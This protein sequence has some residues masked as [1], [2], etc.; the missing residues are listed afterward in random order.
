VAGRPAK[1][2]LAHV[3]EG[4][5]RARRDTHR[6]L[7]LG[8]PLKWPL[9]AS[10]QV[11]YAQATSQPERRAV[12][13]EFELLVRAA[14]QEVRR[15]TGT[16]GGADMRAALAAELASLGSHTSA[17]TLP[18]FFPEYLAHPKGPLL[19]Q[20]FQLERW[21]QQ[22][23]R[24]FYRRDKHGRRVYQRGVLGVPRGNGKTPLA[25]ALGL[26]E[27]LART[28][29]PEIY[30]A[31]ASKEQ[32][33][34]A[35]G[36]ARD[37][38][39]QGPLIDWVQVKRTLTCPGSGGLMQ[40][41]SSEGR[42]QHGR[43][44]AVALIDE[45]WAFLTERE[46]QTYTALASALHKRVDAYLLAITTAG[47]KQ[48][49]LLGDIYQA[50]LNGPDV[51]T[52]RNGCLTVAKDIDN[53]QLLWWYGAPEGATI[54]DPKIWRAANP[55]SWL[56]PHDLKHQLA[57]P[58]LGEHEFRRLHLNQWTKQRNAWLPDRC[59]HNLRS[60]LEIPKGGAIYV[61]VDVGITHDTTAVCLAHVHEDG[62]IILRAHVWAAQTDVDA[63]V[64]MGGG[65]VRL[66]A[67]ED[68][69]RQLARDYQLRELAYD[70]HF[71][72]RSAQ[73]LEDEGIT[74]VEFHPASG[75]MADAYQAFY[76][77]AKEG[78]LTHNGDPILTDHIDATGAV[79]TERGWKLHKLNNSRRIDAAIAA[80]LA[81]ARARHQD[82][83][84]PQ[85]RWM[86]A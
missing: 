2:L 30:C 27:L 39:E 46:R 15:R 58:G 14:Q 80:V 32:A 23:L 36:F 44:P 16:N 41:I 77:L 81:V 79:K 82:E 56:N 62:R 69:I 50:A 22:F 76:Q 59:W 9:F 33:G 53:G 12:A 45:L 24:E 66:E 68:F 11:R 37:F 42:M 17:A 7:L 5:F 74:T 21:Q 35:L 25:A 64:Y 8:P 4:S 55:A 3:Q 43:M 10:L 57:D 31:A 52:S 65:A 75:P 20:P 72:A 13:L 38:V 34:I 70:P 26:Y 61:G 71:F 48:N 18:R 47:Y 1:T 51:K 63:H 40:V 54:D 49:S 29:V 78:R 73:L 67:I 28:D 84:A 6:R 60:D 86:D 19:G 85:I 83:A